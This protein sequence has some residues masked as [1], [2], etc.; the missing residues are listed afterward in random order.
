VNRDNIANTFPTTH[1]AYSALRQCHE[2]LGTHAQAHIMKQI[3]D[4]Q[5]VPGTPLIETAA[6][7]NQLHQSFVKIGTPDFDKMHCAWL[8]NAASQHYR[9]LQSAL[10]ALTHDPTC[11]AHTILARLQDEDDLHRRRSASGFQPDTQSVALLARSDNP[12]RNTQCTNCKRTGHTID[13]CVRQ[14]GKMAGRT[15]EESRAAVA[16]KFPCRNSGT[17]G[18]GHS[19]NLA[20]TSSTTTV[21]SSTTTPTPTTSNTTTSI[22]APNNIVINGVTYAFIPITPNSSTTNPQQQ[23]PS[24]PSSVT[25]DSGKPWEALIAFDD[26]ESTGSHIFNDVPSNYALTTDNSPTNGALDASPFILDTGA[27][28]HISPVQTDFR[29]LRSIP[30]QAVRGLGN[31]SVFATAM[32]TIDVTVMRTAQSIPYCFSSI[33]H[34]VL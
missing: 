7:I 12:L 20:T 13:F 23:T 26:S 6:K 29:N 9:G 22:A 24:T 27:T 34:L 1:L 11:T 4:T 18:S 30:A 19:A 21:S 15:I 3:M 17:P 16:R 14:G 32:G 28:C 10:Q 2:Q 25:I 31:S 5:Y 8:V 33:S